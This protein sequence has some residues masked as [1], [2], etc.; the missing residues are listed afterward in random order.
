M[1]GRPVI[2]LGSYESNGG[3]AMLLGGCSMHESFGFRSAYYLLHDPETK[4]WL[5]MSYTNLK[6]HGALAWY[7]SVYA[8]QAS[9]N[10]EAFV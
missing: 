2:Y 8:E 9:T 6:I 7:G 3:H 1:S 10:A 4:S 5:N